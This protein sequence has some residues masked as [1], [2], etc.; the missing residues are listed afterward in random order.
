MEV[1]ANA[2]GRTLSIRMQ[3]GN[4]LLIQRRDTDAAEVLAPL[5][6]SLD[7]G[8][9]PRA[10]Q[11]VALTLVA[12]LHSVQGAEIR[13]EPRLL[14]ALDLRREIDGDDAFSTA[15]VLKL[16]A[17]CFGNQGKFENARIAAQG[18]SEILLR[19]LPAGHPDRVESDLILAAALER[20]DR[21]ED[22]IDLLRRTERDIHAR[23]G[24]SGLRGRVADGEV[25]R[26]RPVFRRVVRVAWGLAKP[27]N[28][29]S[30]AATP[31]L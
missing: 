19:R 17:I 1:S 14:A 20:T 13:A 18:S 9:V 8:S 5:E 2:G 21:R 15:E 26:A 22:S 23:A 30:R 24:T 10:S 6:K 3:L 25:A 12:Q 4:N 31:D 11:A 27:T 16:L 28:D 7:E 29:G